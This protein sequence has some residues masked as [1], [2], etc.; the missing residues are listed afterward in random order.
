MFCFLFV[1]GNVIDPVRKELHFSKY[2][3]LVE[4]A[5]SFTS[6]EGLYAKENKTESLIDQLT[7]DVQV[8]DQDQDQKKASSL[9]DDAKGD[10]NESKH[11]ATVSGYVLLLLK[12][13]IQLGPCGINKL[14]TKEGLKG[15]LPSAAF[16]P[17]SRTILDKQPQYLVEKGTFDQGEALVCASSAHEAILLIQTRKWSD[18]HPLS[19]ASSHRL[20]CDIHRLLSSE[21]HVK[22]YQQLVYCPISYG[23]HDHLSVMKMISEFLHRRISETSDSDAFSSTLYYG[24]EEE[25]GEGKENEKKKNSPGQGKLSQD[26]QYLYLLVLSSLALRAGSYTCVP[27]MNA[28]LSTCLN[29]IGFAPFHHPP[30]MTIKIA[31]TRDENGPSPDIPL[32]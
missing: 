19:R 8:Q 7:R 32:S 1:I 9:F 14:L 17:D 24:E 15:T 2:N 26:I 12:H 5:A 16:T 11:I 10:C 22:N 21:N 31:K 27:R 18:Y 23:D 20:S 4:D 13:H 3:L 25:E 29:E 6:R 28:F 30:L